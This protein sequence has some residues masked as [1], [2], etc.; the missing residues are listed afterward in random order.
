V[1]FGLNCLQKKKRINEKDNAITIY[2]NGTL[3]EIILKNGNDIYKLFI[4]LIMP[5]KSSYT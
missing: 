3:P 5:Y 4:F 2:T 1:D